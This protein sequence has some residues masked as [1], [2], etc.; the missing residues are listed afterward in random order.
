M[1]R[2]IGGKDRT[3]RG[4]H[5][6]R[7]PENHIS[8]KSPKKKAAKK[9]DTRKS[10]AKVPAKKT[11]AKVGQP[12][13]QKKKAARKAA[14]VTKAKQPARRTATPAPRKT[15]PAKK[16][17]KPMPR[18]AASRERPAA[19]AQLQTRL[20]KQQVPQQPQA[21]HEVHTSPDPQRPDA[22]YDPTPDTNVPLRGHT[23]FQHNA[24]SERAAAMK[25][26]RAR[27]GVRR[28]H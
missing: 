9:T 14:A 1:F 11:G 5:L 23:S 4:T 28:K 10:V 12:V 24:Q 26:Q 21:E 20:R 6:G 2:C 16:V 8:M 25:G 7:V 27:I 19:A 15:A 18:S 3:N 13:A 17:M 22:T